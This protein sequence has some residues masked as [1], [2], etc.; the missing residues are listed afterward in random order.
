MWGFKMIIG[1][2]RPARKFALHKGTYRGRVDRE[3]HMRH[4]PRRSRLGTFRNR[5]I[6]FADF[7]AHLG[8][9]RVVNKRTCDPRLYL[10]RGMLEDERDDFSPARF[11]NGW[12]AFVMLQWGLGFLDGR[13]VRLARRVED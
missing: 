13:E 7:K 4:R 3:E 10:G 9:A 12:L 6:R 11:A 2:M 1:Q 8:C 5:P